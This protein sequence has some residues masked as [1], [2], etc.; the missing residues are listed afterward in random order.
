MVLINHFCLRSIA[1]FVG[2]DLGIFFTLVSK[3]WQRVY[4]QTYGPRAAV[5]TSVKAAFASASRLAFA[6]DSG[7]K[8]QQRPR[9]YH[10]A[11]FTCSQAVLKLAHELGMPCS[12][13]CAR[14]IAKRGDLELMM[15]YMNY[16]PESLL[17]SLLA[18]DVVFRLAVQSG[19]VDLVAWLRERGHTALDPSIMATAAERGHLALCVYLRQS[20]C[21]WGFD[22]L[23]ASARCRQA[24]CFAWLRESGCPGTAQQVY[25]AAMYLN[26]AAVFE[27]L[28][29]QGM[30]APTPD[31]LSS[32]LCGA[33]FSGNLR[34]A[35]WLRQRGAAWPAVLNLCGAE[36]PERSV[37]W[38]RERGCTSPLR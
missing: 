19:N 33:G 15:W 18:D 1:E 13:D 9:L 12:R 21:A 6:Q 24:A 23:V 10:C 11:G 38:F 14:G 8:L 5:C 37:A 34:A 32:M 36:F 4:I 26:D 20:G 3:D 30:A 2:A 35:E 27:W 7:L 25:R 31:E 22:T 28:G 29:A 17:Q 16:V